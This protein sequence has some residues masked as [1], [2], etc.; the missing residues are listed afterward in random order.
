[1]IESNSDVKLALE[2]MRINLQQ[3]FDAGDSLD[4]KLNQIQIGSGAIIALTTTL[5]ISLST[6]RSNC[7]WIV[8]FIIVGLFLLSIVLTLFGAGPKKYYLPIAPEWEELDKQLFGKSE[9]DAI[10]IMLSGYV[11]QIKRN[12]AIN[13]SKVNI[14]RF[15]LLILPVSI[16]LLVSLLFIK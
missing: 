8:F 6:D 16:I 9:R 14:Y 5:N 15:S 7:Y 13:N 4:G 11:D 10:L 12:R 1:M 2:E 3:C